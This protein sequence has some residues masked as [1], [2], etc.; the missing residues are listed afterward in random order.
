MILTILQL[1]KWSG[2]YLGYPAPG[3][4]HKICALFPAFFKLHDFFFVLVVKPASEYLVEIFF[5]I[6]RPQN[7]GARGQSPLAT[8][9]GNGTVAAAYVLPIQNMG[10]FNRSRFIDRPISC[11]HIYFDEQ[12]CFVIIKRK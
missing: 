6:W 9:F 5:S 8:P 4:E 2:A 3:A 12:F 11:N 7:L 10:R 1:M